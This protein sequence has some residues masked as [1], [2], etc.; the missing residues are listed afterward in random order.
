MTAF[1]AKLKVKPEKV[2]EFI[3]YNQELRQ[4]THDNEPD[5]LIYQVL[6][7]RDEE[8]TWICIAEFKDED[9]FQFHQTTD[10]HDRLAPPILD[11]LAEDMELSFYDAL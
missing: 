1:L 10:F 4:L 7:H 6:K 5:T 8:N 3:K 9:A 2:E 11:C